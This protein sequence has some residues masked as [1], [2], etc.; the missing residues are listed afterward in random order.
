MQSFSSLCIYGDSLYVFNSE[1]STT[2]TVGKII[3]VLLQ[4]SFCPKSE[5]NVKNEP[6]QVFCMRCSSNKPNKNL[7]GFEMIVETIPDGSIVIENAA[8]SLVF[9]EDSKLLSTVTHKATGRV[10][11]VQVI[12]KA[13]QIKPERVFS[14]ARS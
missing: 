14:M 12:I 3:N 5:S 9:D 1:I 8:L 11:N 7:G 4:V 2:A 6:T 13:T 10:E